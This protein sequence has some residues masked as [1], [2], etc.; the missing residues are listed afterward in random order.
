MKT[1]T[2]RLWDGGWPLLAFRIL[3]GFGFAAH[4]YAKADRGPAQFAHA[5]AGMGMPAPLFMAWL[6]MLAELIGG[7][8]LMVGAFVRALCLPLSIIMVTA[9]VS[10]HLPYGFSSVKLRAVTEQGAQL[11]P[12]GYEVNLLYLAAL[13]VLA[14]AP[15]TP[16]SLA[17]WLD[18]QRRE[19]H[20]SA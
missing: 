8:L 20:A 12:P 4:G 11:G 16:L 5:L 19:L 17:R 2:Q 7:F 14:V 15:S 3:I 9:A 18:K 6:V 1:L 13:L 10:V